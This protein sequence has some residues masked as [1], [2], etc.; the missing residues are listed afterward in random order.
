[1]FTLRTPQGGNDLFFELKPRKGP[2]KQA[3]NRG[4]AHAP[5]PDQPSGEAVRQLVAIISV[6]RKKTGDCATGFNLLPFPLVSLPRPQPERQV[7]LAQPRL[8]PADGAASFFLAACVKFSIRRTVTAFGIAGEFRR[9]QITQTGGIQMKVVLNCPH[10]GEASTFDT[11]GN[12][13]AAIVVNCRNCRRSF[14]IEIR[15]GEIIGVRK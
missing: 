1:M 9:D 7:F 8:E 6:W 10:C 3:G 13:N 11:R 12:Q 14:Y 4:P 15:R 5:N 2:K